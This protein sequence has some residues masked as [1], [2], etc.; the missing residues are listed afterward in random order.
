MSRLMGR[1][2]SSWSC[3]PRPLRLTA[4]AVWPCSV[5]R[6]TTGSYHH[7]PWQTPGTR[8]NVVI[9]HLPRSPGVTPGQ[10]EAV[11][12]SSALATSVPRS[13]PPRYGWRE[14]RH[15]RRSRSV[16]RGAPACA[17]P[18]PSTSR[19]R[20]LTEHAQGRRPQRPTVG[21]ADLQQLSAALD[22][23]G[24]STTPPAWSADRSAGGAAGQLGGKPPRRLAPC[25]A[26]RAWLVR[27]RGM[28]PDE[29]TALI[30]ERS[31][32]LGLWNASF[33]A[34]LER[35][36]PQRADERQRAWSSPRC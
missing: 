5:R 32:H 31:P 20:A 6:S 23:S 19:Q 36:R 3:N 35:L 9:G 13:G 24:C 25:L 26:L 2:L 27:T 18:W 1:I 30:A 15:L 21:W 29:A 14:T 17:R 12:A 33:T 10:R 7:R 22:G 4:D 11:G 28:S 16:R 34:A 8:T